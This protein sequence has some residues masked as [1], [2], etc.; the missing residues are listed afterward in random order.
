[1][2]GCTEEVLRDGM[3]V[4]IYVRLDGVIFSGRA[5]NAWEVNAI[6]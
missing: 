3:E 4:R 1:M 5:A 6:F 2:T